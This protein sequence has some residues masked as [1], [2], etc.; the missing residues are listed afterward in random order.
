MAGISPIPALET[1]SVA[2]ASLLRG[3]AIVL[4][5]DIDKNK[6]IDRAMRNALKYLCLSS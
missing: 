2:L 1:P 3:L 5:K 4:D 6:L